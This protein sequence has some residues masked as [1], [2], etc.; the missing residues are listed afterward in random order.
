VGALEQAHAG[1][2]GEQPGE[3]GDLGDVGLAKQEGAGRVEAEGEVGE[4]GVEDVGAQV[5]GSRT[6]VRAW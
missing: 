3:L 1:D 4:R 6:V 5:A 2:G